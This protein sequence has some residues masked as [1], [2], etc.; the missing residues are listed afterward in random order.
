MIK[1]TSLKISKDINM[2]LGTSIEI[3]VFINQDK[4]YSIKITVKS[5]TETVV[6]DNAN[7][8]RLNT[9]VYNYIYQSSSTGQDGDYEVI[10]TV[11]DGTN[12][13][14]AQD[15]FTLKDQI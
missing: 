7:M 13:A 14:V 8:N 4:P 15:I 6:V 12:S 9:K 10:V 5:P 1:I 3:I 2:V 11:N